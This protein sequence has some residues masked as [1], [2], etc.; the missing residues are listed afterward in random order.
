M[1]PIV[2]VAMLFLGGCEFIGGGM[3]GALL[4]SVGGGS[5]ESIEAKKAAIIRWQFEKT[6]LVFKVTDRMETYAAKLF[7]DG[8]E[9]E[10]IAML[11][12]IIAFHDENQPIWLIQ[13][14]IRRKREE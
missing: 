9:K 7:A 11:R 13:Q 10:G 2:I 8:K 1:K 14:H 5:I 3:G 6:R 12:E 4:T